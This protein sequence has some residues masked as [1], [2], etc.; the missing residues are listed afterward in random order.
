MA[1]RA[2]PWCLGGYFYGGLQGYY[3]EQWCRKNLAELSQELTG[4]PMLN[5]QRTRG[6]TLVELMVVVAIIGLLANLAL[7]HYRDAVD[8]ARLSEVVMAI[9]AMRTTTQERFQEGNR[10]MFPVPD[11]R[12]HTS[13]VSLTS[14]PALAARLGAGPGLQLPG[15]YLYLVAT[16][17][18]VG[19]LPA[20]VSRS[21]LQM[22]G[23]GVEGRRSLRLLSEVLPP[24]LWGFKVNGVMLF[25][26]LVENHG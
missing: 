25:V 4:I 22:I 18:A 12:S 8:K 6:F 13:M 14:N 20:G 1:L 23:S 7:P 3:A 10:E 26:E 11:A 24:S 21:Y 9:D 2:A 16:N 15:V 19:S 17:D 5:L